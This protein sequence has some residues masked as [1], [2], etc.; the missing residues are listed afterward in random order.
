LAN[1]FYTNW[2]LLR[3]NIQSVNG[4]QLRKQAAFTCWYTYNILNEFNTSDIEGKIK[5]YR[6]SN[7]LGCL[8]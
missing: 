5:S 2:K 8:L 1:S 3:R 7:Y 6:Y 4:L